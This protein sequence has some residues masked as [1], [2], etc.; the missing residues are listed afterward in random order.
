MKNEGKTRSFLTILFYLDQAGTSIFSGNDFRGGA[1]NFLEKAPPGQT[2]KKLH[3][4][5]P[6]TGL[7]VVFPHITL[8]EGE[9]LKSGH[10]YLIRCDVLYNKVS[11]QTTAPTSNGATTSTTPTPTQTDTTTTPSEQPTQQE[12][13]H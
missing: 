1:L 9:S 6:A 12:E 2:P 8:H 5:L 10:K 7:C 4:V 11:T 13:F 3:S